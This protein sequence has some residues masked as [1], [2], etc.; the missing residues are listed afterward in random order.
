MRIL[1]CG[2]IF[3]D[4]NDSALF[5]KPS[6]RKD[7]ILGMEK[8]RVR[9]QIC[10]TD[11]YV[12]TEDDVEYTQSLGAQLDETISGLMHENE[13]LSLTQA[14]ILASLDAMDAYR[15]SESSADNLR[16]QIREYLEDSARARMELEVSRREVDRLNREIQNLR[17]KL[18][19]TGK[20]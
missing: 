5:L 1:K 3:H 15:K 9:L 18:A 8:N 19:E 6:V 13:R 11:Y 2:P 20:K 10:G 12:T 17:A 4:R 14:A 16:S 7:V